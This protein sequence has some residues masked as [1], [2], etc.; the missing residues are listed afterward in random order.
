MN[1]G[2]EE[3]IKISQICEIFIIQNEKIVPVTRSLGIF[4]RRRTTSTAT[5]KNSVTT[6]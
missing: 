5:E 2:E 6:K 3:I 1:L 4:K